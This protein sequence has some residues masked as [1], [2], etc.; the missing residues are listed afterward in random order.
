MVD[1]GNVAG[2][3]IIGFRQVLRGLRVDGLRL[4]QGPPPVQR[5]R[6]VPGA[7]RLPRHERLPLLRGPRRL[8]PPDGQCLSVRC[9]PC[10]CR[11]LHAK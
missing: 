6:P 2:G 3:R 7:E 5:R 9:V 8:R 1:D 10:E 11:V 4:H